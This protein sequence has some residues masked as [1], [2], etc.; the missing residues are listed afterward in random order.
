MG[1]RSTLLDLGFDIGQFCVYM[2]RCTSATQ[3]DQE[4]IQ[5]LPW[6]SRVTCR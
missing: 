6:L 4:A 3:I 2:F 1:F 5:S